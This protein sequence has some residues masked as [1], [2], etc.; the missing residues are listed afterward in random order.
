MA[1]HLNF[2][3]TYVSSVDYSNGNLRN[4]LSWF[5]LSVWENLNFGYFMLLFC[6]GWLRN[7][8][9]F[10][11][12]VLNYC[13]AQLIS[14]FSMPM[15]PS[16]TWFAWGPYL[17]NCHFPLSKGCV[18]EVVIYIELTN[19]SVFIF[20]AQT[21][22][23]PCLCLIISTLYHRPQ[24]SFVH[25]WTLPACLC[26]L[27]LVQVNHCH[28][29]LLSWYCSLSTDTLSKNVAGKKLQINVSIW[30]NAHLPLPWPNINPK[31]LSV[32]LVTG[33]GEG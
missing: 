9:S 14:C 12:L 25:G 24:T 21:T 11:T 27:F 17:L 31:I 29:D 26:L 33:S 5:L 4:L 6:R 20:L 19:V 28:V 15:L 2:C 3:I 10:K 32:D 22:V 7:V 13:C 30:V 23:L 18:G 16:Q 8:Q 1:S